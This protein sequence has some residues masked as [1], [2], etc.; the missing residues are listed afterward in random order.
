MTKTRFTTK[1][2]FSR[3]MKRK[4]NNSSINCNFK[5]IN[6]WRNITPKAYVGIDQKNLTW[7]LNLSNDEYNFFC[8][9]KMALLLFALDY[10]YQSSN[11][12]PVNLFKEDENDG[13]SF[14]LKNPFFKKQQTLRTDKSF[15]S[16]NK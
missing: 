15:Q 14:F 5:P 12:S 1:N 3:V 9:N 13:H 11:L 4:Q 2:I 16:K 7:V 10:T 8:Q 6:F